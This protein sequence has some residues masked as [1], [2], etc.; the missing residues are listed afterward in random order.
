MEWQKKICISGRTKSELAFF[1]TKLLFQK[2]AI[3]VKDFEVHCFPELI[4]FLG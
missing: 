1:S 2:I 3:D 4:V